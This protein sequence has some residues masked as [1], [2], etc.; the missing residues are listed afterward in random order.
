MAETARERSSLLKQ[1]GIFVDEG[2]WKSVEAIEK[3]LDKDLR[4]A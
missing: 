3:K 2:A 4:N 1:D